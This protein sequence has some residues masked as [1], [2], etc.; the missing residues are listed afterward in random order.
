MT[1]VVVQGALATGQHRH[2]RIIAH[3][4]GGFLAGFCQR[5][6]HLIALFKADL[7]KLLVAEQILLIHLV[8]TLHFVVVIRFDTQGVAFQPVP[9]GVAHLE[10]VVDVLG[11]QHFT[12]FGINGQD[13]ARPDPTLGHHV[14]RLVAVN[15]DF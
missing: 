6:K 9:I 8:G 5:A 13:L 15:A 10:T 12:G 2:G 1:E 3:G 7:E 14:F 11:V 4:A